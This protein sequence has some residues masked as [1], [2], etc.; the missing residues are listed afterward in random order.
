MIIGPCVGSATQGALLNQNPSDELM[1]KFLFFGKYADIADGKLQNEVG[2]DWLTVTGSAGSE[3]YQCPNTAQY[4]AADTDLIWFNIAGIQRTTTTA[5]LVGN[6][7]QRTPIKYDDSTP[8]QI[9]V[10]GILKSGEVLTEA[11]LNELHT[12]FAL[13]IYWSGTLNEYGVLKGNRGLAQLLYNA[14]DVLTATGNGSGVSTLRLDVILPITLTLDGDG[15]FYTNSLGTE[16]ESKTW[17]VTPGLL[18]TIYIKVTSGYSNLIYSNKDHVIRFGGASGGNAGW[19]TVT[20]SPFLT[21]SFTSLKNISVARVEGAGSFRGNFAQSVQYV[22]FLHSGLIYAGIGKA[23]ASLKS[24]YVNTPQ[25]NWQTLDFSGTGNITLF[26]L[27]NWRLSKLTSLEMIELLTSLKNRIG[28]LPA[29]VSISDYADYASPPQSVVDA[30]DA[31]KLAKSV[32]TV[33]LG[34]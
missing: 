24:L 29:T 20:N 21:M 14:P 28:S 3:T 31:L 33:T 12:Y 7:L 10:I 2:E 1:A 23:P 16:N 34:A 9:R 13:P 15:N 25:A 22:Y 18:R 6:D 17:E 8:Y 27:L 26:S 4:I 30:V 11:E 5:E 19:V 32:T